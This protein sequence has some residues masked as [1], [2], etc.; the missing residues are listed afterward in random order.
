MLNHLHLIIS[1]NDPKSIPDIIRDF[2]RYTS[3]EISSLLKTNNQM[4]ALKIF[5]EATIGSKNNQEYKI[6]QSG[7]HP[8]GIQSERFFKQKLNYIHQ[9]PVRKGYVVKPE[10][11]KFSSAKD[12]AGY[13][14]VPLLID[15]L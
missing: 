15:K 14:D 9:N 1:A 8:I 11:W 5:K 13:K 7:Y 6:W 12:Y 2:K 10:H 4:N 3:S